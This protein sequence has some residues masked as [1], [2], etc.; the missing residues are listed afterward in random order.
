ME[1]SRDAYRAIEDVV[2]P[3]H[4]TDDPALIAVK[5]AAWL[6]EQFGGSAA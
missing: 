2:G 5:L 1:I 4:V 6:R 3:Q